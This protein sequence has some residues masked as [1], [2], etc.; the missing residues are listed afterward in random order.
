LG[1]TINNIVTTNNILNNYRGICINLS[2]NNFVWHNNIINNEIQAEDNGMNHWNQSYL[3]G[4]NYWSDYNEQSEG[5]YDDYQGP[6]QNVI[7][8][9]GI[10]DN[11]TIG[12]GGKNPYVIDSDSQDNYPLM[13]PVGNYIYL[14]E[15]W[16][17]VSIPFIQTNSD[18]GYVLYSITGS[19]KAVQWYNATD[20]NDHWKHNCTSK[21]SHLNDLHGIDHIMGFWVYAD[22]SS[23]MPLEYHGIQPTENQ[24][25]TLYPG[26]NLVGYPS[27]SIK[28]RTEA[29]NNLNFTE[30]VDAIWTYNAA[31][32][33]WEEIGE[34]D[35]L[36]KGQGY[37]IHSKAEKTWIVPM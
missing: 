31:K 15:G 22:K 6:N 29:L 17:L 4:G 7:G 21:P 19:Y 1:S 12:G 18:L 34:A 32:K 13:L 11:G 9:D 10:V 25:I 24:N 37:Y 8:D 33:I 2:S 35:Y 20:H 5:A 36:K 30:D 27:L 14:Y 28:N 3:I 26:W 16:N 23:C